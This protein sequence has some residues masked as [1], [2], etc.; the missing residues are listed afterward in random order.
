MAD[1][2]ITGL[3]T[4]ELQEMGEGVKR[5]QYFNLLS[6]C[7]QQM[8]RDRNEKVM[9]FA[10]EAYLLVDPAVPQALVFARN[11]EKRARKYEAALVLAFHSVVDILSPEVKMYGQALLDLPTFKV[12]M[13]TDG[14]N[15]KEMKALFGLT[16][17][18]EELLAMKKRKHALFMAGS[19]RLHIEFRLPEYKLKLMGSG[20]GR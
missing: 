3:G 17:A 14:Q 20:G 16:E 8:S 9:L 7:W 6:H 5:A 1:A 15:L 19:K 2:K 11:I 18:E 13:G 12:M 4:H 10:D